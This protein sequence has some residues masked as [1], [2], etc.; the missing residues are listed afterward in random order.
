MS[1]RF[2][3]ILP[4]LLLTLLVAVT[5]VYVVTKLV[6]NTL[7][8]RLTNQLLESGRVVS[9]EMARQEISHIESA[10]IIAF[11]RGIAEALVEDS[12]QKL[13]QLAMPVATGLD[14]ENLIIFEKEGNEI[15]HFIQRSDGGLAEFNPQSSAMLESI[16][17]EILEENNPDTLPRRGLGTDTVDGKYYYFTAIPISLEGENVGVVFI[18]TSL[19]A[20]LPHLKS[21]S[22]ANVIFYDETGKTISTTFG[23]QSA[24]PLFASGLDI[25]EEIYQQVR[26]TEKLVNGENILVEGRWYRLARGEL[27]VAD[28]QLGIFAV[29]LPLE[30]VL[31]T[32]SI[33]RNTYVLLFTIAM[34]VVI[35]IGYAIS[36]IIIRPLFSLVDTSQAIKAGDLTKRTGI[37]SNDE[38]GMLASSFDEMAERLQKHTAELEKTNKMLEQM[39]QTKASFIQVSAHELRTPLTLIDGYSQMLKKKAA[40]DPETSSLINGI[41]SGY[42][43][44]ASIVNNFSFAKLGDSTLKNNEKR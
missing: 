10:R 9:D 26:K 15:L 4:Y 27:R 37:Q 11:T 18:G 35:V 25:T 40:G 38:I 29:V 42:D 36:R 32:G 12:D 16:A 24:N 28:S 34:M 17:Q 31:E 8:E 2:K 23:T 22:I 41:M 20:I 19:D 44:M 43:R 13:R 30:F 7:S 21:T 39:D 14:V 3:V 33:S 6:T 5:G 1:I